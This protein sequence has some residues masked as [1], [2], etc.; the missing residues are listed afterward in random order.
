[1]GKSAYLFLGPERGRKD[2]AIAKIADSLRREGGEEPEIHKFY[3]FEDSVSRMVETALNNSLLSS[4]RLL[5]IEQAETIRENDAKLF[6][7]YWAH[8]NPQA[9]FIFKSEETAASKIASGI[10]MG[11]PKSE[12]V[13][14]WELF[15]SDKRG[16]LVRFFQEANLQAG[17]DT[18]DF[19]LE[20]LEN[21]TAEFTAACRQIVNYYPK[22]SVLS[23]EGLDEFLF[24]SKEESAFSL[25]GK[26]A[27]GDLSGALEVLKKL[28]LSGTFAYPQLMGTLLYQFRRLNEWADLLNE[29]YSETA[30]A[31]KLKIR[32]KKGKAEF[33][34]A[35][36]LYS[37]QNIRRMVLLTIQTDGELRKASPELQETL[38]QLYLYALIVKK[39]EPMET[40]ALLQPVLL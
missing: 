16:W 2:E 14:F 25:F 20:M 33:K 32:T 13:V 28:T 29:R 15:D 11:I 35:T 31:E 7:A 36:S 26:I 24:H 5:L 37:A 12:T 23:A 22:G 9:V 27:F 3:P 38:M 19:L 1:M 10:T 40:G 6:K 8:P 39:G 4:S 21:N 34:K 30:I 18:V 17:A